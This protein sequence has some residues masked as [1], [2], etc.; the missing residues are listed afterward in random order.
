MTT[1]LH[2]TRMNFLANKA[3][4]Y[5]TTKTCEALAMQAGVQVILLSSDD[6][7]ADAAAQEHFFQT[8][9]VKKRF[10]IAS[11][12]SLANRLKGSSWRPINWLETLAVNLSIFRYVLIHRKSFDVLYY[13]DCSLVLPI[14][15]AKYILRKPMFLELHAVL[16][17]KHGQASLNFFSGISDG[18]IAI[19]H[20]LKDYYE[21]INSRI[22]VAFCAAAE[23]ER[24]AAITESPAELRTELSLPRD[25]TILMYAGNLYKTG[26]FDSYGIE[27]IVTAMARLD[28]T[29]IFVGIGKKKDETRAHEK[30]AA[31][32]GISARILFL[33]WVT[34]DKVYR[35]WKAADVLLMPAAGA[36][37][38][39]SPTKMFEYL[40]SGKPIV[41]ARTA[42][43]EEV[44]VDGR[45][46]LLVDDYKAP[47]Q[48][49]TA[50]R[51][52][53]DDANLRD[54]LARQ[55]AIDSAHYTWQGRGERIWAFVKQNLPRKTA[56][57][58]KA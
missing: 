51:R 7:L 46:A 3:H 40:A 11:L 14:L 57:A 35:Y 18:L 17:K 36:Q 15:A 45:N 52:A 20:G 1:I 28:D 53:C 21:K 49:A 30:L 8:H 19:S 2:I 16:H 33:P 27:D 34:K 58:N 39:N 55:A 37:I 13:R 31:K 47:E 25:K 43:I 38:G 22:M 4:V 5:T 9:A 32:L 29:Y 44:L 23:P 12:H 48:W 41:A 42:P 10:A 54:R 50:I 26:N 6:S 24:F 56:G